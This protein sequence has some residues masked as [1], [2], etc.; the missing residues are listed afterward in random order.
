MI[1]VLI[2]LEKKSNVVEFDNRLYL[3]VSVL[4]VKYCTR[5]KNKI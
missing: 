1:S 5:K 2:V 4:I 3:M